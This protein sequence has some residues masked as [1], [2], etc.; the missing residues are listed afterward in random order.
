LRSE[1]LAGLKTI[2][3]AA[4]NTALSP[5]GDFPTSVHAGG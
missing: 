3:E 2:D 1:I 5:K 4:D